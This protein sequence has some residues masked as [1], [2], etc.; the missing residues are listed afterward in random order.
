MHYL[1]FKDL[2]RREKEL[3]KD[4]RNVHNNTIISNQTSNVRDKNSRKTNIIL[5]LVLVALSFEAL[6]A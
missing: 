1:D 4:L 3:W 6:E 5:C 2:N